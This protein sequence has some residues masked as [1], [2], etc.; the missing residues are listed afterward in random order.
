MYPAVEKPVRRVKTA[1]R[2]TNKDIGRHEIHRARVQIKNIHYTLDNEKS[3]NMRWR[4]GISSS[5][6][7]DSLVSKRHQSFTPL[8]PPSIIQSRGSSPVFLFLKKIAPLFSRFLILLLS[9][10]VAAA[11]RAV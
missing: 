6:K 10:R 3:L 2:I 9:R 4:G 1:K 8:G 5:T 11:A 7:V